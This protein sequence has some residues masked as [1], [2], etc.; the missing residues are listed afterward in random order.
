[1]VSLIS[2]ILSRSPYFSS[3]GAASENLIPLNDRQTFPCG[4]LNAVLWYGGFTSVRIL[5]AAF[6][7]RV[8]ENLSSVIS[9]TNTRI[10]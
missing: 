8:R 6:Q 7:I 4:R 9:K 5:K 10:I 2:V 3:T 1:M